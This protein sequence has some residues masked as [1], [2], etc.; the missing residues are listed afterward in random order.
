MVGFDPDAT[1]DDDD[2]DAAAAF[3][4]VCLS[5]WMVWYVMLCYVLLCYDVDL[6]LHLHLSRS[7]ACLFACDGSM[8]SHCFK[9]IELGFAYLAISLIR[10]YVWKDVKIYV[11][12]RSRLVS[13]CFVSFHFV[14]PVCMYVST[15]PFPS[16]HHHHHIRVH[17]CVCVNHPE[18]TE[19]GLG[20]SFFFFFFSSI[21]HSVF[22]LT[23]IDLSIYFQSRPFPIPPMLSSSRFARGNLRW[24]SRIAVC[25]CGRR[26]C[27]CS[28]SCSCWCGGGVW[29]L[30]LPV[31]VV[32][33]VVAA[34]TVVF[35]GRG[36]RRRH[37]R[38][39]GFVRG[40]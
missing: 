39:S 28:C 1:D 25:R 10:L 21:I 2:D 32:V 11:C 26:A 15:F 8:D 29:M 20:G 33:V 22:F 34:G 3:V 35:G 14:Y 27:S 12:L 40:C 30:T 36:D 4:S 38:R 18:V 23:R 13:C 5:V 16:F 6:H 9:V 37:S 31:P 17:V 24:M 19:Q 7:F